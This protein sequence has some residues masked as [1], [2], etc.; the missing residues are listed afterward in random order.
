MVVTVVADVAGS[1]L[2]TKA[3]SPISSRARTDD[4]AAKTEV[5]RAILAQAVVIVGLTVTL[6]ELL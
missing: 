6:V 5:W 2:T 1:T 3:T 4:R